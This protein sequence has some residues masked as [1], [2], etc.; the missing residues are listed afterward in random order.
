MPDGVLLNNSLK[1][2]QFR[3]N[4]SSWSLRKR[5]LSTPRNL[6]LSNLIKQNH[7]IKICKLINQI[8][9]RAKI[10][11]SQKRL[12][13]LAMKMRLENLRQMSWIKIILEL[14]ASKITIKSWIKLK[15]KN[16]QKSAK[17]LKKFEKATYLKM[18]RFNK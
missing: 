1:R 2:S 6:L 7:R 13:G 16:P 11:Q 12:R 3:K 4:K 5:C 18:N 15:N 17:N 8:I 10:N 14:W 9:C